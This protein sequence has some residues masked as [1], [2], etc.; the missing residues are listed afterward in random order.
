[1]GRFVRR[2][3]RAVSDSEFA[4][5]ER[6]VIAHQSSSLADPVWRRQTA[7]LVGRIIADGKHPCESSAFLPEFDF[8]PDSDILAPLTFFRAQRLRRI[9]SHA[10]GV[11]IAQDGREPPTGRVSI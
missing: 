11:W 3:G 1:M 6:T 8:F 2:V 10:R 4:T 9:R 5:D 7:S